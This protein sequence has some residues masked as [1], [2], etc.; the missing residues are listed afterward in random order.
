MWHEQMIQ[1]HGY[2][3]GVLILGFVVQGLKIVKKLSLQEFTN[4]AKCHV[5]HRDRDRDVI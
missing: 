2:K 4:E 3:M 5:V 1:L